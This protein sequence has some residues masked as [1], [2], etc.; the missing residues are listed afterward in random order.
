MVPLITRADRKTKSL[1]L[2]N[3]MNKKK[4]F[5]PEEEGK[6]DVKNLINCMLCPN[7]CRF[8]CGT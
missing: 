2:K 1:L 3:A 7:M 6:A 4:N 8:D 5:F